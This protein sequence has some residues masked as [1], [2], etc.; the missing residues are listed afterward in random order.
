MVFI[1]FLNTAFSFKPITLTEYL[2]AMALA[3]A[4]IPVVET[5]KAI[6]RRTI[7]RDKPQDTEE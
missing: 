1:P 3:L 4:V 6:R 5:E 2:T 7:K